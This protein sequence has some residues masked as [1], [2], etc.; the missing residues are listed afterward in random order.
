M[1]VGGEFDSLK[2]IGRIP[3]QS[4]ATGQTSYV[5]DVAEVEKGIKQP[6]DCEAYVDE[7][8]AILIASSPLSQTRIDHWNRGL[9][10]CIEEFQKKL[11]PDLKLI[12]VFNQ[13]KYVSARINYLVRDLFFSA[14]A[15]FLVVWLMMGWRSACVVGMALPLSSCIV[16]AVFRMIG[17]PLHQM[18]LSGLVIALECS[19]VPPSSWSTTFKDVFAVAKTSKPQSP[20]EHRIWRH[21]SSAVPQRPSSPSC[22]SPPCLGHQENLSERSVRQ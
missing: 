15:V 16:F 20:K 17:I 14:L 1:E 5:S 22:R 4:L 12:Q 21:H 10:A 7:K 6:A 3:I 9:Q 18:S 13:E 2:R 11:P 8:P 19:K